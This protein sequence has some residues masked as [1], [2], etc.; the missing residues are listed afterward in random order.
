MNLDPE[1]IKQLVRGTLDWA[2]INEQFAALKTA[3]FERALDGELTHHLGYEK[4]ETKPADSTNRRNSTSCQRITTDDDTFDVKIPCD[5][6]GTFDPVLIAKGERCLT[7][8]DDKIIAMY[9]R[10]MSVRE[11]QGFQLEMYGIE[12]SPDF[13]SMVTDEAHEW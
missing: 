2:T 7:G 13:V 8:F 3:I 5:R 10:D 12:V 9:T 11:I 4:G 6:E 1:L